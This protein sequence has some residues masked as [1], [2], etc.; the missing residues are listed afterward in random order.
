MWTKVYLIELTSCLQLWPW[1][2]DRHSRI[3]VSSVRS[4]A[5]WSCLSHRPT[6]GLEPVVYT[7][8]GW[9]D[10]HR[11]GDGLDGHLSWRG[12]VQ[13]MRCFTAQKVYKQDNRT[14]DVLT[15]RYSASTCSHRQRSRDLMAGQETGM[16]P[17]PHIAGSDESN[18]NRQHTVYSLHQQ[19]LDTQQWQHSI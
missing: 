18:W 12:V 15:G 6:N 5:A 1:Q 13:E 16:G 10:G 2:W 11:G 9:S 14:R 17:A 7:H 8:G 3:N 19:H 4:G